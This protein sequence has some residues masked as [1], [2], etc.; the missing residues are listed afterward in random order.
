MM[1]RFPLG[2]GPLL[3]VLTIYKYV[4]NLVTVRARKGIPD[5]NETK[6][7]ASGMGGGDLHRACCSGTNDKKNVRMASNVTATGE[8]RSGIGGTGGSARGAAESAAGLVP[9]SAFGTATGGISL[10]GFSAAWFSL[11]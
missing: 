11:F 2:G 3:R 1:S 8:G 7:N 9:V 10:A 6:A 5:K 4:Y